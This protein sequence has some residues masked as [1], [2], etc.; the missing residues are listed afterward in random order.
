MSLDRHLKFTFTIKAL[1]QELPV[2]VLRVVV[3]LIPTTGFTDGPVGHA[4][5]P[6]IVSNDRGGLLESRLRELAQLRATRTPIEIRGDICYST[7]TMYL[8]MP[9]VCI[10]R[11]T[12]FGFHGPSSYGMSLSPVRF[13][14]AS[15]MIAA[16]YPE[17]LRAW[18]LNEGRYRIN[19]PYFVSGTTLIQMGIPAC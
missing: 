3:L 16:H 11:T 15:R 18:Y 10:A 12:R 2:A 19:R 8:G 7:C 4:P 13:E 17:P 1:F 14:N 6:F 5:S 9:D